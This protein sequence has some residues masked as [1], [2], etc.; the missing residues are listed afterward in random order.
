MSSSVPSTKPR[1]PLSHAPSISAQPPVSKKA[2]KAK[3]QE[4]VPVE[5]EARTEKTRRKL[6]QEKKQHEE[7][8]KPMFMDLVSEQLEEHALV[9][10]SKMDKHTGDESMKTVISTQSHQ[11]SVKVAS[12]PSTKSGQSNTEVTSTL[13]SEQFA[14]SNTSRQRKNANLNRDKQ[15]ERQAVREG[16]LKMAVADDPLYQD[17]LK[18]PPCADDFKTD[19]QLCQTS[20]E[21]RK[22]KEAKKLLHEG[23]AKRK[24]ERKR[25]LSLRALKVSRDYRQNSSN[26]TEVMLLVND[27]FAMQQG[28]VNR[29]ELMQDCIDMHHV[30][31]CDH[32]PCYCK[33]SAC[34]IW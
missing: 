1:G 31:T 34:R 24:L 3:K 27:L 9:V 10:S 29:H 22:R 20:E 33:V 28:S 17:L 32:M 11:N 5:V 4:S 23:I 18:E 25:E 15:R 26:K 13:F 12:T 30:L 19:N 16:L 21:R 6:E 2:K 7:I 8:G 14:G